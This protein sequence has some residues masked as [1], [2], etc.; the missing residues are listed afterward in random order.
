VSLKAVTPKISAFP[1][2]TFK[3]FLQVAYTTS[4]IDRTMSEFGTREGVHEFLQMRDTRLEVGPNRYAMVHFALAWVGALQV[5][6]IQPLSGECDTYRW[7]LTPNDYASRLHHL[8]HLIEHPWQFDALLTELES[9]HID[10]ALI[11]SAFE[12]SIRYVYTDHRATL[13]HYVEHIWYS[14]E[15]KAA[16]FGKIPKN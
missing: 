13:G 6:L 15:T 5:E 3:S 9:R 10:I 2:K 11:G 4:D 16:L 8:A 12:G 1:L 14:P 7:G